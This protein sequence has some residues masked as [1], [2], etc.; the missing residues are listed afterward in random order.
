ME[1]IWEPNLWERTFSPH[2]TLKP[3]HKNPFY[4]KKPEFTKAPTLDPDEIIAIR[5][6]YDWTQV[7]FAS[8]LNVSRSVLTS[9]ESGKKRPRGAAL[10]LLEIFKYHQP[11]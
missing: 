8:A 11:K 6:A 7:G 9:W 1:N 5:E 2:L 4:K 10:R 3:W